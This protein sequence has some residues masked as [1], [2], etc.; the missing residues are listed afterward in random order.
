[1]EAETIL[2]DSDGNR[3]GVVG[4]PLYAVVASPGDE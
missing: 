1:M 2:I 4:N 3:V